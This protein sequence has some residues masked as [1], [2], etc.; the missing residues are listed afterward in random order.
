M[1]NTQKVGPCQLHSHI[2]KLKLCEQ[3][4]SSFC[5]HHSTEAARIKFTKDIPVAT[6][7]HLLLL[8]ILDM[9]VAS[10]SIFHTFLLN[11]LHWYHPL[12]LQCISWTFFRLRSALSAQ[13]LQV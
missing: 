2:T 8:I 10:D 3:F 5:P 9:T 11:R 6:H 12:H 1:Q 7:S 13:N 4:Q